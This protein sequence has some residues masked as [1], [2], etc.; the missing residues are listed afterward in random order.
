M[1]Y[2]TYMNKTNLKSIVFALG[3][4][5]FSVVAIIAAPNET[6]AQY[7]NYGGVSPYSTYGNS[8]PVNTYQTPPVVYSDPTVYSNSTNPNPPKTVAKAKA[9]SKAPAQTTSDLTANAV[10]G[11]D[12]FLPSGLIQWILF[13]IAVLLIV[14]I[15][16]KIHGGSE[17][18]HA[19]PL[20]HD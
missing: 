2:Y 19:T 16:R 9:K 6:H 5:V 3:V 14:I 20:K 11:S 7:G 13:G 4:M 8:V 18:Y 10:F 1:V 15:V 12:S 17:K